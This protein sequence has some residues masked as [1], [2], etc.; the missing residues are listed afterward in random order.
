MV[1]FMASRMTSAM[2][3]PR[4]EAADVLITAAQKGFGNIVKS[5]IEFGVQPS[6]RGKRNETA[7]HIFSYSGGLQTVRYLLSK[8]AAVDARDKKGCTPLHWAA[9]EG[10]EQV[11]G[12]LIAAGADV[13]AKDRDGRTAL[14]G[15]AGGGFTGVVRRLVWAKADAGIRGGSSNETPL[16]RARKRKHDEIVELLS[17][18]LK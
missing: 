1:S 16:E 13:N 18:T 4:E 6:I 8:G 14:F 7:L 15:A 9:W 17:A 10:R 11:V 3:I 5:L 2:V 12:E